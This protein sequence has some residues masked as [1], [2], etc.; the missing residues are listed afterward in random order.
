MIEFIWPAMFLL[1]PLPL[2]VWRWYPAV[3]TEQAAL[4]APFFSEWQALQQES[5]GRRVATR[6]LGVLLLGITWLALVTASARP[7]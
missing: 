2:L 3:P 6:W 1:L 7:T 5:H 4:R